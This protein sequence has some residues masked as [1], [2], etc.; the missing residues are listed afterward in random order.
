MFTKM[1]YKTAICLG[2]ILVMQQN[3]FAQAKTKDELK[4][5][6]EVFKAEMKSK[7]SEDRKAKFEKLAE[8]K[9]SGI[10][11]VDELA[12]NSTKMLVSTKEMNALIPE[13]YKRTVGESIDGVADVT[14]KKPSLDE[15]LSLGLIIESQIK[16]VSNTSS[17]ITSASSDLKS[18]SMMQMPKGTKSL[19][20]SKDVIAL[21]LPELNLNLKVLNNLVATLKSSSNY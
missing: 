3:C 13:M 21:V 12:A 10:S 11:S 16:A 18:A 4:A 19:N 14:V 8:P 17:A 7:E 15:L 6:R 5:E 9:T 1:I 20:F 2:L